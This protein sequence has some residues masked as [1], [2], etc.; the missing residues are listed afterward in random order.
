MCGKLRFLGSKEDFTMNET[1]VDTT[2]TEEE[3]DFHGRKIECH[4]FSFRREP[5]CTV[6]RDF[7]N[8][9]KPEMSHRLCENCP[10]YKTNEEFREGFKRRGR[11]ENAD[12]EAV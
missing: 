5:T 10:F 2:T 9:D 4:F 8:A 11:K 12:E 3:C 1:Y 6:L 7:Y